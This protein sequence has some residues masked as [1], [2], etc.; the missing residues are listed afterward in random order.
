M[1]ELDCLVATDVRIYMKYRLLYDIFLFAIELLKS[2]ESRPL[3]EYLMISIASQQIGLVKLDPLT[4][5][6]FYYY[7]IRINK[8]N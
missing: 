6:L 2:H 5:F 1:I 3:V 7:N 8:L 4:L